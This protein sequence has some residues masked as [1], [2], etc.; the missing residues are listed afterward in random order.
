MAC[1]QGFKQGPWPRWAAERS[2]LDS[3]SPWR[4]ARFLRALVAHR[5]SCCP[6]VVSCLPLC[7]L[8][9]AR[10]CDWTP[11]LPRQVAP[12]WKALAAK[13]LLV[14]KVITLLYMRLKVRPPKELLRLSEQAQLTTLQVSST[15]PARTPP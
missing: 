6:G 9:P 4:G 12:L 15:S 11:C 8:W 1:A 10:W 13:D 14:R 2:L 3:P 5:P 7:P